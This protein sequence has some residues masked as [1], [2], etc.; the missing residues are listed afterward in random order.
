MARILY[1]Y[2]FHLTRNRLLEALTFNQTV[3]DAVSRHRL[4]LSLINFGEEA[5]ARG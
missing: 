3:S 4:F 2:Q 5:N 1:P